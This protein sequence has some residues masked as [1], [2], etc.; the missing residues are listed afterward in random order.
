MVVSNSLGD[1]GTV[2]SSTNQ[3]ASVSSRRALWFNYLF[4]FDLRQIK[5]STAS[6]GELAG[7]TPLF[8]MST[9]MTER[10]ACMKKVYKD[11]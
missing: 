2:L 8:F 3:P 11:N 7:I 1:R 10:R 4:L 5:K 6:A 9:Q